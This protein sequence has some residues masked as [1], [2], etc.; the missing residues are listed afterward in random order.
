MWKEFD[1]VVFLLSKL[2]TFW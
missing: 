1:L 2:S